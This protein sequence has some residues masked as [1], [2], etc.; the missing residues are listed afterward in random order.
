MLWQH[1]NII[2]NVPPKQHITAMTDTLVG[3][4][5]LAMEFIIYTGIT[6]Q[7]L[8]RIRKSDLISNTIKIYDVKLNRFRNVIVPKNL[9]KKLPNGI[10]DLNQIIFNFSVYKLNEA[11]KTSSE[12]VLGPGYTYTWH[13]LHLFYIEISKENNVPLEIVAENMGVP[14]TKL[15]K[16]FKDRIKKYEYTVDGIYE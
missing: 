14:P 2:D 9:F 3:L 1:H 6:P 11:L 15:F 12:K 8:I 16:Y 7:E 13:S 4:E 5:R 10:H